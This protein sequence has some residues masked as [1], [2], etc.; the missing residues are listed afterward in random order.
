MRPLHAMVAI[1]AGLLVA[2]LPAASASAIDM[3]TFGLG[4]RQIALG[5][6]VTGYVSDP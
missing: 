2:M 3:D 4:A 5:G 1:L 6:A